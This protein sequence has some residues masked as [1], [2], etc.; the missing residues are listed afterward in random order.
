MP[1]VSETNDDSILALR[2]QELSVV[3]RRLCTLINILTALF[4]RE[5]EKNIIYYK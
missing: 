1:K 4:A 2:K 3:T 5:A